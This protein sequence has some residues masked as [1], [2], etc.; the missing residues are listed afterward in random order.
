MRPVSM[1][2]MTHCWGPWAMVQA[3]PRN[4]TG[5]RI[6][7]P[8]GGRGVDIERLLLIL[9]EGIEPSGARRCL[10][11]RRKRSPADVVRILTGTYGHTLDPVVYTQGV[12]IGGRLAAREIGV[13]PADPTGSIR[14]IA[15]SLLADPG[16]FIDSG[17]DGAALAGLTWACDLARINGD[18][19]AR[20][21]FLA[22][23]DS[24]KDGGDQIPPPP[25]E[26]D[27][28]VEDMYYVATVLGQAYCL[29][30]N[31]ATASCW[32][33]T[34]AVVCGQACKGRTGC[35]TT[36]R[37]RGFHGDGGTDSQ[38]S[39]TPRRSRTW[40]LIHRCVGS[41]EGA[42]NS[43]RSVACTRRA[44][45]KTAAVGRLSRFVRRIE[46]DLYA[47]G[48]PSPRGASRWL[49]DPYA[50]G[51]NR[52]WN[53]ASEAIADD[54][55][56]VDVCAGTG[57]QTSV[58]EYLDRPAVSGHDDRGGAMAMWFALEM[59]K[60]ARAEEG[61][62]SHGQPVIK[63]RRSRALLRCWI[64]GTSGPRFCPLT[65]GN[66]VA[67]GRVTARPFGYFLRQS[68]ISEA[69][70]ARVH[71]DAKHGFDRRR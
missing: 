7:A 66:G 4:H 41:G 61:C 39:V 43:S 52:C 5:I 6:T 38:R 59:A 60:L 46:R 35:S 50:Q 30:G 3:T 11:A 8:N 13:T 21:L 15:E 31:N 57:P 23:A 47:R 70:P 69:P 45:G 36:A 20:K 67:K 16:S 44:I 18:E 55:R 26:F 53:A 48:H 27:F 29:T 9:K 42:P 37:E 24:F 68:S 17:P 58:R 65:C 28:R 62:T 34:F 2:R 54:G 12:S 22:A 40:R 33:S 63:A 19:Q 49:D 1:S 64:A 10:V 51:L 32:K 14:Q 56:L 71:I 25:A